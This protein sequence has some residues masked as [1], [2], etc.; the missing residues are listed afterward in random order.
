MYKIM[1]LIA[2]RLSSGLIQ[3]LHI[4][5]IYRIVTQP[6]SKSKVASQLANV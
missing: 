2:S 6:L 1:L 4:N 5:A 3:C